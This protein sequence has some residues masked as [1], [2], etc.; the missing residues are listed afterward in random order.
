MKWMK[1]LV[2]LMTLL[3]ALV[4]LPV[5]SFAKDTVTFKTEDGEV[6]IAKDP[7]KI[8]AF[9]LG[10]LDTLAQ[11]GEEAR[12]V[13]GPEHAIFPEHLKETYASIENVGGMKDPDLEKINALQPDVIFISSRQADFVA[14]F[15][16][17]APVV[18][19]P[20][21]DENQW[22]TTKEHTLA[23]VEL[24]GKTDQA[25]TIIDDLESQMAQLKEKAQNKKALFMMLNE[26][27]LSV[28]GATSRYGI[29]YNE[30]GFEPADE[31]IDASSHGQQVTF[32][33]VLEKNPDVLFVLD[34]QRAIGQPA[35]ENNALLD[36]ELI[37]Q[38]G[39]GKD[40]AI[41]TVQPDAWYLSAGGLKTTQIM[42]DDANKVL[43]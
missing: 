6:E 10:T 7:T 22:T 14:D 27:T 43:E 30:F 12:V 13:G 38:T 3:L 31:A 41:V 36:N 26:G 35:D 2:T 28:F 24:V 29:L 9:D 19:V 18:F 17:I 21:M 40:G 15:E 33:Y 32:E 1:K 39:A 4:N 25:Q 34:R 42:I 16:K 8:I 11:L 5:H 37:K 23:L 20:V